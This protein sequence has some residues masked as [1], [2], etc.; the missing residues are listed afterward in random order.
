MKFSW[1]DGEK[2]KKELND[3]ITSHLQMAARDREARGES[4]AEAGEA[5]RREL[6]NAGVEIGRAHV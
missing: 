4:S 3:E 5:A 2:R 1:G 6:G